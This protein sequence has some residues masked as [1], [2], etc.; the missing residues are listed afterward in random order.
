MSLRTV[1]PH[2]TA[3]PR[4]LAAAG[5]TAAAALLLSG[6]QITSPVTTDMIYD[7]A[8]G[9]S[10][11][12][13]GVAVR[14]LLVVSEGQ[15]A[16]G[17]VSGL[18]VNNTDEPVQVTL[19]LDVDGQAQELQPVIEVPVAGAVRLDGM[20]GEDSTAVTV[21]VVDTYAGGNLNITVTT[22]QGEASAGLAPIL[23]PEGVYSDHAVSTADV[24]E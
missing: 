3:R 17:M 9:V 19:T 21:P 13:G 10:V 15:G 1:A 6:C 2:P 8:D 22:D 24:A 7:P 11:D 5:L 12:V 23:L 14:D 18:V 20:G 16:A 4:R